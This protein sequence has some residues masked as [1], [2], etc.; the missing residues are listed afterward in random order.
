MAEIRSLPFLRH[1]RS[2]PTM[3]TLYFR[4]GRL[5]RSGPGLSLWLQP[6]ASAV[7]EVPRDD[8]ELDFRFAGRSADFQEVTVQGVITFRVT[9]AEL[10]SSRV[11]FSV[12]LSSGRWR[13]SPMERLQST[14]TQLAQEVVAGY[15]SQTPLRALLAEG[16]EECRRLITETLEAESQLAEMGIAVV[17]VRV[18]ALRPSAD[19]EKA[20]ELPTRER[21]Q[22]EADE[23]TF[24]RRAQAVEKERAIQENELRNR[25]EL[26]RR[27]EELVV[28]QGANRR[29]EEE[30]LARQTAIAAA[31][32][33]SRIE[34]VEGAAA[35]VER[36]RAELLRNLTPLATVALVLR[37]AGDALPQIG[38]LVITPDLL[39]TLAGRLTLSAPDGD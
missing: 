33:A 10:L 4:H 3:E 31:A 29:R 21:I 11:D 36:N 12:D 32:E 37:D 19:T 30:E 39:A 35:A 16:V 2:E 28:Q 6:L 9:N 34:V 23:A 8:R 17:A 13:R 14:V 27:E 24:Q 7:A 26:A 15:L 1:L 5:V 38:Q 22:E 18:S 20:L 25:I